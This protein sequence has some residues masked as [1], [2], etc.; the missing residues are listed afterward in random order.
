[1]GLDPSPPPLR[2]AQCP[3][4]LITWF[5]THIL[6]S[7]IPAL[8]NVEGVRTSY[9]F[10]HIMVSTHSHTLPPCSSPRRC[11]RRQIGRQNVLHLSSH[12]ILTTTY[13]ISHTLPPCSSPRRCACWASERAI[14]SI[15]QHPHY[16]IFNFSHPTTLQTIIDHTI[17]LTT[18]LCRVSESPVSLITQYPPNILTPYH[19][20]ALPLDPHVG[21]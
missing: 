6:A 20:T 15:T 7:Y 11:A 18:P 16:S 12:N 3:I 13:S 2:V 14:S 10:H 19:T 21:I 1:M 9:I 5:H 17:L 8:S 4:S